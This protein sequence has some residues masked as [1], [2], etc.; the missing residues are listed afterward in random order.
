[1]HIHYPTAISESLDDLTAHEHHLRGRK[2]ATRVRLLILLK[3]GQATTLSQAA[4]LVGYSP[5]QV[6]RWWERYRAGGLSALEREP[7]HLGHPPRLT[8]EARADLEAAMRR[9]EIATLEA[10]RLYLQEHW[11][12]D[13]QSINGI[14]WQFRRM[15][16]RKKT[17][18]RRHR[19]ASAATQ[20]AFKNPLPPS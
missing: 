5:T 12:I 6:V 2:A 4:S 15:R 13:Y 20:E 8:S 9:G 17:G 18:R 11:A 3:S 1:M 14:W 7:V 19:R 10:A 16:V